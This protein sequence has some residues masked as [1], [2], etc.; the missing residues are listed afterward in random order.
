MH[1]SPYSLRQLDQAYLDA[2]DEAALRVLSVKL[3]EDLK[4]AW[5]RLNQGAENSSRPPSSRAPWER[6][7]GGQQPDEDP[8]SGDRE[9][10]AAAAQPVAAQPEETPSGEAK[11]AEAKAVE[12]PPAAVKSARK[13]GKQPGALGIGRTQ[14]FQAHDEQPHYPDVCAG[15]GRVLERAGAVAYTGFQAVDLRWGDPVQP[16]LTL[17]V[18]DHRYYEVPCACG[19]RTRAEAGQG[20]VDPLLTGI[21]LSEWRLVGPGLAALIVALALRFRLSRARIREFLSEW[22]GLSLSIGTLQQTIHE[23]SAAVAPAEEELIQAVLDSDLLHADET[24]WPEQGQPPLW[25]WV[26][27]AAT[28][29]L[30]YVAGRGKELVQNVLAGFSG[31]LMTDGWQAYRDYW[32]RLRCWTHLLR[33]ARGLAESC[34]GEARAFGQLVLDT[35]EVLMAAVYAAREGPPRIDL[36][37]QHAPLLTKLRTACEQHQHSAHKK[38]HALAVEFLNDWAA[39]FQVL[40]HPEL[41]LTNNAAERALRHWVILRRLSYGTRTDMGSRI[42]ALLA[43]VVDTC[44]QRGHSPWRYLEQAIADRRAGQ[45]LAALPR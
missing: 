15:C 29:T 1:L 45:P 22:L 44:R 9:P 12:V 24:S 5:D 41:P 34:D 37:T 39:I 33:K 18:V 20:V 38:T 7:S 3:L 28:V 21:E 17:W 26:F 14:V 40:S 2:L 36:P 23:A 11:P 42:F 31:W 6:K 19:H 10:E 13:A 8:E 16:G 30:Y 32:R 4:E 25:L 43:S 35:L 27:V